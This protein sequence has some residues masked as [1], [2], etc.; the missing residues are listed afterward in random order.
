MRRALFGSDRFA[1][2]QPVERARRRPEGC[3][4]ALTPGR[5]QT[6][7]TYRLDKLF[8]P[9]SVALVGAS[10]RAGSLGHAVL[11]N[12]RRANPAHPPRLIN[13]AHREIDGL[14]CRGS[15]RD[16]DSPPDLVVIAV[17]PERVVEIAAEAGEIG[18]AAAIVITAGLG[19]G[20]GSMA[21]ALQRTARASGLRVV[22]PN[23]IGVLSPRAALDA[24]F[25]AKPTRAGGLAVVTQSGAI[26]AAL[27]EWADR[28]SVG[29]S[30]LVSLGDQIDVDFGDCLDH[31]ALDAHSDAILLYIEAISDARKFLSAARAAAR[32]KPVIVVKAGRHA[33]GARAALSHTGALAGADAVYDAAFRR[34]GLIRVLDLE[35]LFAAAEALASGD[36][37]HGERIGVLTNGGGLG[38]LAVD[39]LIDFGGRLAPLSEATRAALDA[40]L[41]KTW[42]RANPVDIIG[43]AD[44]AR[45]ATATRILLE[46]DDFDAL[47]VINCST[48]LA[49]SADAAAAVAEARGAITSLAQKPVF[50]VWLGERE[51]AAPIFESSRI[52]HFDN[53]R[54]AVQGLMHLVEHR[55]AQQ[56]LRVIPANPAFR[57]EVQTARRLVA[58]ALAEGRGWLDPVEA[59]G[60][61]EA[62][63]IPVAP[64]RKAGSA[65]EAE[66]VAAALFAGHASLAMKILS[67][68]ISHKSDVG[69][70]RLGLRDVA[71]VGAAY[72]E[73][74][75][76]VAKRRP[77][78]RIDGVTLQPMI[79][80]PRG[81]ELIAGL[82]DDP[83]FGPVVLFG[84]GG[85][86]VEAI[87]DRALA[88]PP[89]DLT[90]ARDLISRTRVSRLLAGY[91]DTPA[92]DV[93]AIAAIL[94]K[95]A[96]L[97]AD[98][99]EIFEL[100]LNPLVADAAGVVAVD[101]RVAVA[102]VDARWGGFSNPRFAI[103]PYPTE[104][105]SEVTPRGGAA[106]RVR[107]IRPEDAKLYEAFLHR[108][109]REALRLRFFATIG[110]ITPA[111]V[112]RM[113]QIDYARV[114]ALLAL[115]HET[116]DILGVVRLHAD[117]AHEAG[118]FAILVRSDLEGHGVGWA[119]M[120]KI[121]A[122]ARAE[123][124]QRVDGV[125]LRENVAMLK[126]CEELGFKSS[127]QA[128]A[129]DVVDV[130]LNLTGTAPV[131]AGVR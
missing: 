1:A 98:V 12:L 35:A 17:P 121:L 81:V 11:A 13:P 57:H 99:P 37:L 30:G 47:L 76:T 28:N 61:L 45:Y 8:S 66:S 70:V 88:L 48:A 74:I 94:V 14:E 39:R 78:A 36:R 86:A 72:D 55:R 58:T 101:V 129:G 114:M 104:W 43:D 124:L 71:E 4:N 110:A 15:L 62:Y 91:R 68:D 83:T 34:A 20:A 79:T 32:T 127:P 108:V 50:A 100:D 131:T 69:G 22:G 75:A 9:Q 122:F 118:E 29:F 115:D 33:A 5:E 25:L 80:R 2:G 31:F 112:S 84:H 16:F 128:G 63:A 97:S 24:S 117:S 65:A 103:R 53:E 18:A 111:F 54:D 96:Q 52:P 60:L 27:V 21:E 10:P 126:M 38:V 40:C 23:C 64:Y 107:P 85:V 26:A 59:T 44:A 90:L 130:S 109:T 77:D 105:E 113:T 56:A 106:C 95:L 93:D 51:R 3:E 92:A 123:G 19:H 102:K 49:S 125:V 41:P 116:G 89:L 67:R 87:G 120:Q 82:G 42:S 73:M 119:L 46:S 7:S 6:V